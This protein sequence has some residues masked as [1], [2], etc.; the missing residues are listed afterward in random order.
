MPSRRDVVVKSR[1]CCFA[2]I[3]FTALLVHFPASAQIRI[4]SYNLEADIDTATQPPNPGTDVVLEGIG[5]EVVNGFAKNLDIIGLEETSSNTATVQPV[6]DSLNAFYGA[7]TYARSPFQGGQS[8]GI[9]TGNG[10]NALIY[11]THTLQLIS[12]VGIGTT[13]GAN[14]LLGS[15][16][17]QFPRQEVRYE[18]RPVGY[19]SLSTADFY[20]YVGHYKALGDGTSQMRRGAEAAAV[21]ADALTL[22]A[23]SRIIY[24]GDMNLTGA[25]T[26]D[27][28]VNLTAS[29]ANQAIDPINLGSGTWKNSTNTFKQYY[30]DSSTSLGS[31]LD[32]ELVTAPV[33]DGQGFS[34]ITG[35]YH[36]FGNNNSLALKKSAASSLNT[37][38]PGVPNRTT[39]LN[40][41]TTASDHYPVVADYRLPAILSA[42]VDTPPTT[43]ITGAAVPINVTVTNTAPVQVAIGAD[44]LAYTV[45][46]AGSLTGNGSATALAALSA[47]NVHTLSLNTSTP[48]LN[49]G[50]VTVNSTSQEVANGSLT[51]GTNGNFTKTVSTTVLSHAHPSFDSSTGQSSITIDFGTRAYNSA[52]LGFGTS[53]AS[54]AVNNLSDAAGAALTAGL[55]LDSIAG[56]GSTSILSTNLAPSSN[57]AAADSQNFS[58]VFDTGSFGTYTAT[59][60]LNLSDQDLPGAQ[61]T[62]PLMLTITGR[63]SLAGDAN[64]DGAVNLLDL[65]TLAT[66]FGQSGKDWTDGDFNR[67]GTID[68][69]DF[70]AL[71][72]DFGITYNPSPS[73]ALGAIVPEPSSLLILLAAFLLPRRLRLSAAN[74]VL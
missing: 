43:V 54:F 7:G 68:I 74:P 16:T 30:S 24:T 26:D 65:N 64:S 14:P 36:T 4:A 27:A 20:V 61:S 25:S 62:A 32:A 70:N 67:D 2:L 57:I 35:S 63:V 45:A 58:A 69:T 46:S 3:G 53:S 10:P 19:G 21:R 60:T 50:T 56:A 40:D 13:S 55:D 49:T 39:I 47:G 18:F 59:Y 28:W 37:A 51:P 44:T 29:G 6:V 8:G 15:G 71:A 52:S 42:S 5:S 9:L 1:W 41:L 22:P 31:R 33:M 38:L 17:N 23:N 48:G 72:Q 73:P 66:N 12:S 11:N 34:Y